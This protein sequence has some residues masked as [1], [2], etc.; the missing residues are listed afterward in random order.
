MLADEGYLVSYQRIPITDEEAPEHKDLDQLVERIAVEGS[1]LKEFELV[2]NCQMGRGRTTTAMTVGC[3]VCPWVLSNPNLYVPLKNDYIPREHLMNEE[4]HLRLGHYRLITDI[5]AAMPAGPS[6]KRQLD[7]VLDLCSTIQNLREVQQRLSPTPCHTPDLHNCHTCMLALSL[8][9][10]LSLSRLCTSISK[11]TARLRQTSSASLPK[12][13]SHSI[14][15]ATLRCY[16]SP[17]M[18][19]SRRHSCSTPSSSRGWH[20]IHIISTF[21]INASSWRSTSNGSMFAAPRRR[22]ASSITRKAPCCT[23]E[24]C[25]SPTRTT[26]AS[27]SHWIVTR[28]RAKL[29]HRRTMARSSFI[30]RATTS[31]TAT[32]SLAFRTIARSTT[33]RFM[34]V[35]NQPSSVSSSCSSQS[36]PRRESTSHI[37]ATHLIRLIDSID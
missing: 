17:S 6:S 7:S 34:D 4:F 36:V 12:N 11:S 35:V 18:S 30:I 2:F 29:L 24:L 21:A 28:K 8:S 5:R 25:S 32:R 22:P 27:R 15:I 31:T 3:L 37:K 33:F 9:L 13:A 14:S 1:R 26:R 19:T 20:S 10:S 23:R 16:S